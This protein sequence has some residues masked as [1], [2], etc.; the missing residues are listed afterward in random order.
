MS[1]EAILDF[2]ARTD[3]D[4]SNSNLDFFL[5]IYPYAA[6][7]LNTKSANVQP[8]VQHRYSQAMDVVGPK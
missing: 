1:E 3:Q 6:W 5:F 7:T 8:V 4:S 2:E